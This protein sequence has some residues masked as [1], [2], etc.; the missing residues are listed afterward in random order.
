MNGSQIPQCS[1]MDI[2]NNIES[3]SSAIHL[4]RCTFVEYVPHL[5]LHL[6][7]QVAQATV[8]VPVWRPLFLRDTLAQATVLCPPFLTVF[9]SIV[10]EGF[11]ISASFVGTKVKQV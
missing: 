2:S 8:S 7:R 1:P 10:D 6:L 4:H 9:V 3:L 11:G 5:V